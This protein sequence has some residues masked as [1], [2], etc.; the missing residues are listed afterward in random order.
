M[1]NIGKFNTLKVVKIVDFGV[2]LDG[3]NNIEILLPSRYITNVPT[4][5]DEIDVFVYADSED[6]LI[7]T[8]ETPYTQVGKFAFL[9]V[10]SVNK[11]GAF[12]NWGL[13]KD[14]L[15]PYNEQRSRMKQGRRYLVY[16]YLDDTTK[17][18]V[19]SSK[20][21]K[22]LGNTI[23]MYEKGDKVKCLVCDE[24]EIGYKLIID[25]LHKGII[26]K[27]EIFRNIEIGDSF[28]G[29]IKQVRE[30][31][32]I[33]VTIN[34]VAVNRIDALAERFYQFIKI[35][36]GSTMLCDKSSPEEIK[37]I[38]QCSKKDFKKAIGALYKS[39]RINI[40][41][42]KITIVVDK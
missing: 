40:D 31:N 16:T 3:G 28:D 4:I 10:A 42:N 32:K 2:Y 12:L 33:D 14:L 25:D 23:P 8:T 27:N 20:Y 41:E 24:N 17:R 7:A 36:G 38:L 30:D 5:G 37:S 39:H 35:N 9:E 13:M 21:E 1:L 26:Y 11:V 15:V 18:I 34:D 22:F 6:R 19:A 29:Y